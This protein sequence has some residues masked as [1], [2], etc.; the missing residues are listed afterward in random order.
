MKKGINL[1]VQIPDSSD[2]TVTAFAQAFAAAN[3]RLRLTV[4]SGAGAAR[5]IAERPGIAVYIEGQQAAAADFTALAGQAVQAALARLPGSRDLLAGLTVE[6]VEHEDEDTG[7]IL[8]PPPTGEI[9]A[10]TARDLVAPAPAL[11]RNG[12]RPA[13]PP[14]TLHGCPAG[15]DGHDTR[16]NARKNR[17]DRATWIPVTVGAIIAQ[18]WP[19]GVERVMRVN[20]SPAETAAVA[21]VEGLPLQVEGWLAGAKPEGPESCNCHSVEDKDNHLWLVD[22]PHH[23]RSK[24]VVVEISPRVRAQHPE[25]SFDHIRPLVDGRTKVRISGWLMLDQEHPEQLPGRGPH[26]TRATL[27]EIHPIAAIEVPQGDQWVPLGG[28]GGAPATPPPRP[29]RKRDQP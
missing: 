14:T 6:E 7:A 19:D 5:A 20:W 21:E 13:P 25:W 2:A 27:W 4:L 28:T 29:G 3:P 22:D 9:V 18:P 11:P 23:D 16:L 10:P 26:T 1:Q 8:A 17:T 24:S 12:P 15:G